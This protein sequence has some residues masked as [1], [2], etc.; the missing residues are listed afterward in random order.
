MCMPLPCRAVC[1]VSHERMHVGHTDYVIQQPH[2]MPC[3]SPRHHQEAEHPRWAL[4][5][6]HSCRSCMWERGTRSAS[7][8]VEAQ[9]RIARA[10]P[11]CTAKPAY[12]YL[13][14]Q[15]S[16]YWIPWRFFRSCVSLLSCGRSWLQPCHVQHVRKCMGTTITLRESCIPCLSWQCHAKGSLFV[17]NTIYAARECTMM[18]PWRT[19]EQS[20][21]A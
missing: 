2:C 14:I 18:A 1:H 8:G 5:E 17:Y 12:L 6:Q 13:D 4:K 16:P 10:P 7:L 9:V 20:C 21:R 15:V 19:H 3:I 11:S